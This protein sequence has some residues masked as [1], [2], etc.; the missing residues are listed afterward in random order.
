MGVLGPS[1]PIYVY[2]NQEGIDAFSTSATMKWA[3]SSRQISLFSLPEG[4]TFPNVDEYSAFMTSRWIWDAVAP[5]ENI[6]I[7]QADSILCSNAPMSVDDFL[8]WDFI[9]API[10]ENYGEGYNGGLSLRRRSS[11]LR[12]LERFNWEDSRPMFEDQWYYKK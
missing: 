3:V 9:G 1:W 11:T 7:F 12:L 10:S 8:D 6:F 2:T 4:V 5:A